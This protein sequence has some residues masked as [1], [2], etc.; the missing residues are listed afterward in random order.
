MLLFQAP[1]LM[2]LGITG[3]GGNPCGCIKQILQ[4]SVGTQRVLDF[5]ILEFIF[6]KYSVEYNNLLIPAQTRSWTKECE[7]TYAGKG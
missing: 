3:L 6:T 1:N 7:L 2:R 5:V 4:N